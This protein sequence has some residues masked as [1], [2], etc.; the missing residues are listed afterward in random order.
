MTE[1]VPAIN[2]RTFAE[3]EAQ[4]RLAERYAKRIHIDVADGSFT[5]YP[6]W[7][8]AKD[9]LNFTSPASIEIHFMVAD[10][11]SKIDAWLKTPMA[12][13]IFHIEAAEDPR[14]L[15]R[16]LRAAGKE[17]GLAVT[18]ST[19]ADAL[20][21]YADEVQL[22]QTLAVSPGP[23]GQVFDSQTIE[24]IMFL[25]ERAPDVP[26]EVDGGIKPGVAHACAHAGASFLVVG[27]ALFA[28][29]LPFDQA[30]ER[31]KSDVQ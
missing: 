10:P 23:S 14:L 18:S 3:V 31:L 8:D 9:L 20:L 7:H 25:K 26:I 12:R 27:A 1:I 6:L 30:F 19:P 5:P 11:L 13:L 16:T 4:I 29:D 15:I 28:A 21:P 22:F 24:K 17:A 2:A